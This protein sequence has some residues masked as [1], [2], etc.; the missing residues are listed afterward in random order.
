MSLFDPVGIV[1]A[2]AYGS[3][4][5]VAATRAGR[6][7][8]LWGRDPDRM[9][10]IEATRR[11]DAALPDVTLGDAVRATG[12]L[13]AL[14]G[15]RAI[16]LTTPAQA[17]REIAAALALVLRPGTPVIICAKGIERTSGLYPSEIAGEA[18]PA[19]PIAVLSGPSFAADVG[20]GLPTALVLACRDTIIG[21]ALAK[22]LNSASLRI[23]HTAD[24]RGVE[25]GGAAKNVLAIAAGIVEAQQLGESAKAALIARGFA[26]MGRFARA[27]GAEA[28]TLM[29]LSG[30]GDLVLTCGSARSRNF[31]YGLAIGGGWPPVEAGKDK[32]AEGAYTAAIL[33]E[34]AAARGVEMPICAA[35]AAIIAGR[36]GVREAIGQLV[37]RPTRAE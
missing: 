37:S 23:Y 8:I 17:T 2:G 24:T 32:L 22:A 27:C 29:G 3:A 18:M 35:V 19:M 20:R 28:E 15:A 33:V 6:S 14:A 21:E 1:G 30:L 7:V 11:N 25:I 26:E 5:A 34:L 10:A 36:L 4:L 12:S 9:A 31:S 16:L 13:A